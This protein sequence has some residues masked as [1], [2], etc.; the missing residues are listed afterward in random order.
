[1]GSSAQFAQAVGGACPRLGLAGRRVRARERLPRPP[2]PRCGTLQCARARAS[3]PSA[4]TGAWAKGSR[5]RL[6]PSLRSALAALAALAFCVSR[7]LSPGQVLTGFLWAGGLLLHWLTASALA[8]CALTD[9]SE[10]G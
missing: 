6:L 8:H 3:P 2:G 4:R 9:H 5:G 1:M 7:V 10:L